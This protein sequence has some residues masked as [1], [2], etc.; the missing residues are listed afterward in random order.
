MT[1]HNLKLK[2]IA[3]VIA[4]QPNKYMHIIDYRSGKVLHNC[5]A[6]YLTGNEKICQ[7][8]IKELSVSVEG[9]YI[10]KVV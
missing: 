1:K 5:P 8:T 3:V 10:V 6:H 2:D 7:M 4:P 9:N